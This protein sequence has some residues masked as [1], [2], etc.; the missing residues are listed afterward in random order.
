MSHPVTITT[1]KRPH[2]FFNFLKSMEVDRA[3][4]FGILARVWAMLAGPVTAIMV[5][6]HFTPE[7][8]GYYY[9]FAT[10]IALQVFVELG[11]GTVIVQFASHEWSKLNLDRDG[12]I[13]GDASSL[14]RLRSIAHLAFRWYV[15]GGVIVTFGLGAAGYLF[16]KGSPA[17]DVVWFGPWLLLC[18]ATGLNICFVPLWSLLEGCNQVSRLYALRLVLGVCASLATWVAIAIGANLWTAGIAVMLTTAI[19]YVFIRRYYWPFVASLRA[20]DH[21]SAQIS[22]RLDMLPMQWRIALSWISG[23]FVFSLFTPVLFKFQ[24]P[25]IAGQMGMT[26]SLVSVVGVASS[27]LMPKIPRFGSLI[28]ERKYPELD[29]FFAKIAKIV[30]GMAV[31]I[32][33]GIFVIVYLLNHF[34]FFLA[35]R[36]LPLAPTGLFLVA[37]TLVVAS[38][39]FSAYLRAHK[40]E[41]LM[42]L[43]LA[44]AGLIGIS[45]VILGKYYSATGMAAGYLIINIAV[46]PVVLLIWSRC[47]SAWHGSE[48]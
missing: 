48:A 46:F 33:L 30:A 16:F 8:Q 37:Q 9:T 23:Y 3:V 47:R 28:A 27:W 5:A 18:L 34:S 41:P 4:S 13:V 22:W 40:R 10:V 1:D 2:A 25:A 6:V 44:T 14:S 17:D 32:S 26:W 12:C 31:L 29:V 38:M 11:L 43:S 24:G 20:T 7:L 42:A 19:S 36:I 39:P 15:V 21:P 35:E 45:T